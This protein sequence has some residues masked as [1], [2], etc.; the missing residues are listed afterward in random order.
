MVEYWDT[1]ERPLS[2]QCPFV[3]V[4]VHFG[5]RRSVF[6]LRCSAF[7]P[8]PRF[9]ISYLPVSPFPRFALSPTRGSPALRLAGSHV[10]PSRRLADSPTP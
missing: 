4:A 7:A 8:I 2:L 9:P 5:I 3:F 1:I 10:S 6:G